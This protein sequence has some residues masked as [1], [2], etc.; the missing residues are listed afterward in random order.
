MCHMLSAVCT[1]KNPAGPMVW[2]R[3]TQEGYLGASCG[4]R[5]LESEKAPPVL[6][7]WA[8][9]AVVGCGV[10]V[11]AQATLLQWDQDT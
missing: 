8:R 2:G 4:F 1:V 10:V 5:I 11:H 7:I 3:P 6:L 9:A